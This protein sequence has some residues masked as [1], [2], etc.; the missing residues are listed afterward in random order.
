VTDPLKFR[1]G[2]NIPN[3][4]TSSTTIQ[5]EL[6]Y[7]NHVVLTVYSLTGRRIAVLV[8][9]LQ[10]RGKYNI[11]WSPQRLPAGIYLYE[12]RAGHFRA[13]RKMSVIR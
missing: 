2:Q 6:L 12:L 10:P 4:F 7:Q 3:P 8:D 13:V 11:T 5:Y 1:L 9:E